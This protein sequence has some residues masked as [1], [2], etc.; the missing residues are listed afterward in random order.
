MIKKL[1]VF[2]ASILAYTVAAPA[3]RAEWPDH[4]I[5]FVVGFGPGG[6]NDLIARFAAEGVSK[7]LGL[8]VVVENRP[9]A[10][11]VIGTAFVAHSSPDGYTF[12]VGA[13][14]TITNSLILKD[15]PYADSD[16][17]PVGMIAVAPSTIIVHPSVP[18]N[19]MAE[20]V[21]WAKSQDSKGITWATAGNGS[22]P[23]FVGEMIKEATGVSLV[24]VPYKSGG[25]GVNAVLANTVSATSEASIVVIPK[26]KA[27][28][29]KAIAT[30]YEKRISAYPSIST[31]AEQGFPSVQIGHWAGLYAPRGTPEPIIERMNAELQAALKS[32]EVRGKLIATGIEPAGGSVADFVAFTKTER[33]RLSDLAAKMKIGKEEK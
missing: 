9:G 19:N 18:A 28:L 20:F 13:A 4:P 10:G 14:N 7:R 2:A 25:D 21:A 3:A 5:R 27:G 11:A 24:I 30:T 26:I 32:D 33:Q 31:T 29:L 17:V 6:A 1:V 22:T 16:L 15:L 23:E 12:L 8:P